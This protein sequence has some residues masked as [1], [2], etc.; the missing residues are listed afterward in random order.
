MAIDGEK[1]RMIND[2]MLSDTSGR[3][4]NG[5][6]IDALFGR[7]T[8]P[9]SL[10]LGEADRDGDS[11]RYGSC[12][13]DE[14]INGASRRSA[15]KGRGDWTVSAEYVDLGTTMGAPEKDGGGLTGAASSGD[16][17]DDSRMP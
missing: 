9:D 2:R 1:E 17:M 13:V 11:F 8:D 12:A 3:L 14:A 6:P 10:L 4:P 16:V 5:D 15:L 7:E